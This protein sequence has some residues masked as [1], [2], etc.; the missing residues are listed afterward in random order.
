MAKKKRRETNHGDVDDFANDGKN[1]TRV[2]S[3]HL[4]EIYL[5]IGNERIGIDS[6]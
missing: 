2:L 1:G 3:I 6:V 5:R 4:H